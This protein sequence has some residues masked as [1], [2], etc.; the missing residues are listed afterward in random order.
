MHAMRKATPRWCAVLALVLLA[1]LVA[2]AVSA[3]NQL[4][5]FRET[6]HYLR[7]A[8]RSF[9]ER[10]GSLAIF[11]YPITEEYI[12]AADGRIVQYFER[13]RF[14]L[15][16][17]NGQAVIELGRLGVE[18]T[19]NKMF[20][21]TP[22]FAST[23]ERRYF[24]ETGHSL[25]G[26]FKRFWEGRGGVAIF[27][28][29]IS[30]EIAERLSDGQF[31]T[32]Q[33]FERSRFELWPNGVRL[34]L[35]GR[36]QAPPQLLEPWPANVAPPGPLNEDGTPRP[37]APPPAPAALRVT[38]ATGPT[39][40]IFSVAGE[41]FLPGET[42]SL[43]LTAPD[44]AVRAIQ[45][46][47]DA[48]DKGSISAAGLRFATDGSFRAG[49]WRITAQ[50]VSSGRAAIAAFTIG[51]A[52]APAPAPPAPANNRLGVI[53]HDGL[54]VRGNGSI[55]PFGAPPGYAFTFRAAGFDPAERVGVWLTRPGSGGLEPLDDRL[56]QNDG[57]G[58]ITVVF[59]TESQSEGAWTITAQGV[60][61]GR[62]VTAPFRLT[63]DYLAPPGTPLPAS[64][65]GRVTP[66]SGGRSTVFQLSGTGFRG[67]E[68]VEHWITGP[69]GVYL[70]AGT[71]QADRQGR[72]GYSP[73][74]QVQ[75]G[76]QNAAG[77]Y[78][79]HFRGTRSGAR[80]DLYFS[81]TGGQ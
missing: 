41:G 44:G 78:G 61:T 6:G 75:L 21:V 29:P 47:L 42:V 8:F 14:E 76:Q 3:Q 38:P 81:F 77:V 63:R 22:P 36:A 26:G 56:I 46:Q 49:R 68:V 32:V 71:R 1:T 39:G 16:V 20:P 9:W 70:L 37:P 10:N 17:R 48:D 13:A 11:G 23:A 12:R 24:P 25:Q 80:V 69:D 57:A 72:I 73:G 51:Q 40:Q 60:T 45:R 65:G 4:R 55:Q 2:P 58:N 53:A 31:H 62:S 30:E 34:A 19:G 35:L 52:Q 59:G 27:G 15:S 28:L 50:G 67:D 33:Y 79:Y 7:G 66:T 18:Q 74:L 43:W 54:G 64:R 5:Y